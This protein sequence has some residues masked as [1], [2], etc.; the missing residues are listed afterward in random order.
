MKAAEL[1]LAQNL[2]N[3]VYHLGALALE[4][5]GKSEI[6]GVMHAAK[7]RKGQVSDRHLDDHVR[8]L[9]WALW[10]PSFGHQ[11]ISGTQLEAYRGL[12]T[13]IH[14]TRLQ[15]LRLL[16]FSTEPPAYSGDWSRAFIFS[17][18]AL[19]LKRGICL[20]L[21]RVEEQ[22]IPRVGMNHRPFTVNPFRVNPSE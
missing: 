5:I 8:K 16:S 14:E 9:F 15:G 21:F 10:G 7:V 17:F 13:N 4:E 20:F 22:Q 18:R 1:L 3:I 12:A 19:A 11:L 6:V 2:C